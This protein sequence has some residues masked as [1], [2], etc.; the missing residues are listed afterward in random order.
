V[1]ANNADF[2]KIDSN[3]IQFRVDVPAESDRKVNYTVVYT[4]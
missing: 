1:K 3:E 2:I 4:W